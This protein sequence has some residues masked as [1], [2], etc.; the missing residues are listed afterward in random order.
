MKSMN[1]TNKLIS[2]H[3]SILKEYYARYLL[4]VRRVSDSSVKHYF[5]ALNNISRRLR[6]KNLVRQNIYEIADL[7][8]L[9]S[10]RDILYTDADFVA[11]N[12]RGNRMYS[13]GLNN[14]YRFACGEGFKQI[15]ER[16][17]YMDVPVAS[18]AAMVI[19]QSVW[20]RSGILRAQAIEYAE[21]SCEINPD[22]ESFLAENTKKP[23]MEG[24]H[25][26]PM[27]LQDRFEVSLDVYAN[28]VCLC[29][30]CHRKIHYGLKEDRRNMVTQVYDARVSRLI[31]SGIRL[32]KQEF[33]DTVVGV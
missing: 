17:V 8:Q 25:A 30:I 23:Y 24:H 32:S 13:T 31:N 7:E 15:R 5:D 16:I 20:K 3:E 27:K 11:A 22:H 28:I 10:I 4:E 1:N 2:N 18:E 33:V 19:E 6:E 29:P 26:L 9:S 12:Q 21:Y 14:Y